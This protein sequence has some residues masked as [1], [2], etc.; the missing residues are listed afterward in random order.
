MARKSRQIGK[1]GRDSTALTPLTTPEW[2]AFTREI[3]PLDATEKIPPPPPTLAPPREA[4]DPAPSPFIASVASENWVE[5]GWG[6]IFSRKDLMQLRKGNRKPDAMV[7]LHGMDRHSAYTGL[8]RFMHD[9]AGQG[10]RLLLV[11]T[12]KGR[13]GEGVLRQQFG[14][15][16]NSRELQPLVL[17]YASAPRHAGGDGAFYVMLRKASPPLER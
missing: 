12:G 15:W 7:D 11:I 3:T 9:A 5:P 6:G 17:G 4:T 16:M 10:A 13:Q 8:C 1:E 14:A 2:E